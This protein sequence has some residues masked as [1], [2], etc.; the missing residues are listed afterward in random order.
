MSDLPKIVRL[1]EVGPRE[2]FQ[3]EQGPIPTERKVELVD[4]LSGT[5]LDWIEVTSFVNPKRVPQ[6]ADAEEVSARFERRAGITYEALCLNDRALE[7]AAATEKFDL[8][9][10]FVLIAS[11]TFSRRNVNKSIP[12]AIDSLH[13]R[14]SKLEELSIPLEGVSIAAA[15]GCN[16]EGDVP[17]GRVLDLVSKSMEIAASRDHKLKWISLA[18]T[19]GWANPLQIKTVVGAVK[20]KWPSHGIRL[21]LHDT[22]GT[23]IANVYAALEMGVS[24]FESS[25]AGLGG[26]PFAGHRSA[27]GNVCTEDIAFMCEEMGIPTGVDLDALIRC[28]RLAEEIVGHPLPGKVMKSGSLS[29]FRSR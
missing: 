13:G 1:L 11:D 19:M 27:A 23:G 10:Y 21:H 18:D 16:Y 9:G 26:C 3:F 24:E 29:G 12:E 15:F 5:G 28:A 25:L 14:M 8:T 20:E 4:A 22:R 7:R 2:G 6:M 17:P